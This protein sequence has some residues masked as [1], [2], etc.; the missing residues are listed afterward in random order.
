VKF[1]AT[2]TLTKD[3]LRDDFAAWDV[4]ARVLDT[5]VK[6]KDPKAIDC[7]HPELAELGVR[8]VVVGKRGST[9]PQRGK[10]TGSSKVSCDFIEYNPP[11]PAPATKVGGSDDKTDPVDP[12]VAAAQARLQAREDTYTA[13]Q[14]G[15]P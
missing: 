11:K 1:T 3:E 2:W 13:L 6:P 12:R 4:W 5:P 7:Y 8:S 10:E 14:Q 9:K 15:N